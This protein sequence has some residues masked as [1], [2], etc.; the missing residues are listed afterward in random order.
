MSSR[1]FQNIREKMGICY[2]ISGGHYANTNDGLFMIR[3]G[4]EKGRFEEGRA[5]I[6]KEIEDIANGNI[7]ESEYQK[8]Q[9]FM[10]GKTQMG[11]ESSDELA[12]FLGGQQLLKGKIETLEEILDEY[13]KVTM[14]DLKAV[15]KNLISENLYT[16]YIE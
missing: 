2:Y 8:A 4:I 7:L 5:A 14:D 9:G 11:I 13:K 6:L 16:Y 10:S 12:D 15:A 3:A 1:L